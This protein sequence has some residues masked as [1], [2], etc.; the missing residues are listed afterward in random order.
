MRHGCRS[1]LEQR[2]FSSTWSPHITEPTKNTKVCQRVFEELV[3][4]S[5]NIPVNPPRPGW[6]LQIGQF[7]LRR[8]PDLMEM[9]WQN[10]HENT[11]HASTNISLV[12]PAKVDFDVKFPQTACVNNHI[13]TVMFDWF[14]GFIFFFIEMKCFGRFAPHVLGCSTE[15]SLKGLWD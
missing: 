9:L 13:T 10:V 3:T 4:I 6:T 1:V 12:I 2:C 15:Y 14:F 7:R 11:V 5:Q 8:S